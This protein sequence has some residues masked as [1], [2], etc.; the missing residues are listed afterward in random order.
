MIFRIKLR[1]IVVVV[2]CVM[3]PLDQV[4]SGRQPIKKIK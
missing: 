2:F 3:V 1:S 4:N